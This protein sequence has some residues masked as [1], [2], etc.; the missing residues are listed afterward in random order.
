MSDLY[1]EEQMNFAKESIELVRRSLDGK[2]YVS[3][4]KDSGNTIHFDILDYKGFGIYVTLRNGVFSLTLQSCGLPYVSDV[5]TH[6]L[7]DFA[8]KVLNVLSLIEKD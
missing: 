6:D 3:E 2:Y 8:R 4:L 7:S 1:T 5:I